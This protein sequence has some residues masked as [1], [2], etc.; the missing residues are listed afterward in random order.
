MMS[1]RLKWSV[2]V[3]AT[4]EVL[5]PSAP[6]RAVLLA[7][8]GYAETGEISA[9][10]WRSCVD[11]G[12]AVVAPTAP[13]HF[14]TRSQNVVASWM[15]SYERNQR[16]NEQIEY[17]RGLYAAIVARYGARPV[18][19]A[20]FSQGAATLYRA[21]VLAGLDLRELFVVAGDMPPEVA[22]ALSAVEPCPLTMLLGSE[23]TRVGQDVLDRD[24]HAL[25]QAGWS[26]ER[27]T[28]PGGHE[29]S[30][31]VVDAVWTRISVRLES[32]LDR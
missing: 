17:V 31:A 2:S 7:F 16:I 19:G 18:F 3:E 8:H 10:A 20:G 30:D 6:P 11:H 25:E 1:E 21:R 24:G 32:E 12:V 9:R 14:Y 29:I 15:T 26:F 4:A 22:S 23:D 5:E 27:V 13:H 28:M